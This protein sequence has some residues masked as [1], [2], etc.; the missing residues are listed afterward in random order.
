VTHEAEVAAACHRTIRMLDGRVQEETR[1][2]EPGT[3]IEAPPTE[4][5]PEAEL[6][7]A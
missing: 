6:V 7:L 2:R 4:R 3:P 1:G 5:I